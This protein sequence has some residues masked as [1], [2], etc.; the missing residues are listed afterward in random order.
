MNFLF[1]NINKKNTFYKEIGQLLYIENIDVFIVAELEESE[2]V[3]LLSVINQ[4]CNDSFILV[5]T[6]FWKKVILFAKKTI[7]INSFDESGKRIGAFKIFS[8]L[9]KE[10]ILLF[11]F[12]YF[13]KRNF[14]KEEQN[15]RIIKIKQFIEKV[16]ERNNCKMYSIVCGDFNLDPF[17]IPMIKAGGLHAVMDQKIAQKGSRVVDG[18]SYPFFYNPMWGFYGDNGKGGTIS[19]TYYYSQSQTIEYFWHLLDQVIIRPSLIE[20]FDDEQ[21]RIITEVGNISLLK[22]DGTINDKDYSDHLPLKFCVNI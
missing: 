22:G 13:D 8:P 18:D 6:L 15:E 5:K 4:Q 3:H 7:S 1:W 16:E 17:E 12:H 20:Y 11:P 14:E 19:G 10:D 9:L 2:Q 21:L